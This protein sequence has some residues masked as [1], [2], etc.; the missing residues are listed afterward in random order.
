MRKISEGIQT[1]SLPVQLQ[2]QTTQTDW[3]DRS[4]HDERDYQR[5]LVKLLRELDPRFLQSLCESIGIDSSTPIQSITTW[6]HGLCNRNYDIFLEMLTPL[7]QEKFK[8]KSQIFDLGFRFHQASLLTSILYGPVFVVCGFPLTQTF[9]L[10]FKKSPRKRVVIQS[11]SSSGSAWPSSFELSV[12]GIPMCTPNSAKLYP[13]IDITNAISD[14]ADSPIVLSCG[15]ETEWFCLI[16]RHVTEY[17]YDQLLS[18][19]VQTKFEDSTTPACCPITRKVMRVPVRASTCEH[20]HCCEFRALIDTG[21]NL[22]CPVCQKP[23]EFADLGVN[24]LLM[25]KISQLRTMKY[26]SNLKSDTN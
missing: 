16:I 7:A 2:S 5:N 11:I 3:V 26:H 22:V 21:I 9:T 20:S 19:V 18:K 24:S 17:T 15:I 1:Q 10:K 23:I 13:F 14:D 25:E 6:S 12:R 4:P 8:E